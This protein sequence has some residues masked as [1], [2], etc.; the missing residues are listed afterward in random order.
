MPASSWHHS[1]SSPSSG[2]TRK[3]GRNRSTSFSEFVP[4]HLIARASDSSDIP[5]VPSNSKS[6]SQWARGGFIKSAPPSPP[7]PSY[8]FG[9]AKEKEKKQLAGGWSSPTDPL[10]SLP[11]LSATPPPLPP[12]GSQ[13]PA[14]S[15]QQQQSSETSVPH[16]A[17][18]LTAR[19]LGRTLGAVKRVQR[20]R[21]PNGQAA[22]DGWVAV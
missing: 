21:S 22:N 19:V 18:R 9:E 12:K 5:T 17:M 13:A 6:S 15:A 8:G 14:S 11:T 16:A 1:R 20:S 4:P 2:W 3:H 7:P 10:S